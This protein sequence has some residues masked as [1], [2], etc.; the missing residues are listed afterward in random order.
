[1]KHSIHYIL[2]K[3]GYSFSVQ[4]EIIST[5]LNECSIFD[6][7]LGLNTQ[8][9]KFHGLQIDEV[10]STE[11]ILK[12]DESRG[13]WC[14]L[15]HNGDGNATSIDALEDSRVTIEIYISD[16]T[17]STE[18]EIVPMFNIDQ[19]E[20]LASQIDKTAVDLKDT[21]NEVKYGQ[22]TEE[23]NRNALLHWLDEA[24]SEKTEGVIALLESIK[25][26]R[27]TCALS[28]DND[29][30]G[31]DWQCFTITAI[32]GERM[33]S[34]LLEYQEARSFCGNTIEEAKFSLMGDNEALITEVN[35][36]LESVCTEMGY[37]CT[38]DHSH[39]FWV[40][41]TAKNLDTMLL[42]ELNA[43]YD[44]HSKRT[45]EIHPFVFADSAVYLVKTTIHQIGNTFT[46]E[47]L[48]RA[49]SSLEAEQYGITSHCEDECR[50]EWDGDSIAMDNKNDKGY[51]NLS[52]TLVDP[53]DIEALS[54]YKLLESALPSI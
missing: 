4:G 36:Y 9:A 47:S 39:K 7:L 53:S 5:S 16:Y 28:T 54:R 50:L 10:M 34:F 31:Q 33:N 24:I 15:D 14:L 23:D 19:L 37:A 6:S 40:T 18:K 11:F 25:E 13:G 26:S 17:E 35:P 1:M 2:N 48:V 22:I 29:I 45:D 20:T 12:Q 3:H 41:P 38:Y 46:V 42:T 51:S 27:I 43:V 21:L 44:R 49:S 8:A 52:C 32:N 30:N